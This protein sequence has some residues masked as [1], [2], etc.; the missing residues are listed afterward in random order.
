[1]AKL[2]AKLPELSKMAIEYAKPR[3]A[4]FVKY[5]KVE[6]VPPTPAE[7]PQIRSGIGKIISGAKSGAWRQTP[8][9][10]AWL[11]TLVTV[12]VLCWFFVGECIGKRHIVGYKV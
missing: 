6:L 10:E 7:I 2:A 9:K 3:I 1:M 8:V 12:E 4:L 5:A 11:N